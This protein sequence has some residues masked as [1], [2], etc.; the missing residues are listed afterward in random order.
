MKKNKFTPYSESV[1]PSNFRY[2]ENYLLLSSSLDSLNG[3]EGFPW[4]F[5]DAVDD[6]N[7]LSKICEE[8]TGEAN[9]IPFARD[10]DWAACFKGSDTSGNPRVYVY[11]L[12]NP[13]ENRYES[14]SF[15]EWLDFI[16]KQCG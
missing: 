14:D 1:L 16:I 5:D 7:Q 11:D 6:L 3:I 2:P 4:W 12:G 8:I 9:L 15:D 13:I 10:G